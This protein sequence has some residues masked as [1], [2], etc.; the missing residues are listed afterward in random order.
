MKI[1]P[2]VAELFHANGRKDGRDKKTVAFRK[3]ANAHK[4]LIYFQEEKVG[5][6][7]Y[8]FYYFC[9][10]TPAWVEKQIPIGSL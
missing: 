10:I 4:I 3:F 1:R 2:V 6:H 7:K 9:L 8:R 5:Q